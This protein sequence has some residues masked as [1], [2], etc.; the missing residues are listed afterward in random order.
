MPPA[1]VKFADIENEKD[2]Q[3]KREMS[4]G[5]F[6]LY[7]PATNDRTHVVTD[8]EERMKVFQQFRESCREIG[9]MLDLLDYGVEEMGSPWK[10][11]IDFR[12]WEILG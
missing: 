5:Y 6:W 7:M 1:V 9:W 10:N 8:P 2:P 11:H 12:G 3:Q 4:P